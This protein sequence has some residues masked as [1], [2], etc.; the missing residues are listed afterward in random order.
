[1]SQERFDLRLFDT[2][3][4]EN[5]IDSEVLIQVLNG[6]QKAVQLIAMDNEGIE[7][8]ERAK[9]SAEIKRTYVLKCGIPRI[10]S[11]A[12]PLQLGDPSGSLFA[13]QKIQDVAGKLEICAE[14]IASGLQESLKGIFRSTECKYRVVE[15]FKSLLP[16]PGAQW[17]IGLSRTVASRPSNEIVL[18]AATQKNVKEFL[19]HR[20][21]TTVPQTVTGYL[22]AMDFAK[23]LI[24]IQYPETQ[25]IL[26]CSYDESLEIAL[27]ENR[28][29]LVQVTGKVVL[30][31][32]GQIKEIIEVEDI[33]A[34]D[35]SDFTVTEVPF[36]KGKLRF[37]KPLVL[38]PDQSESL[39]LL[40]LQSTGL[41]IDVSASTRTGLLDEIEEQI[42]ALWIEY[43]R[44]SDSNLT[45]PAKE[46][47][48]RLLEAIEEIHE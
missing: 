24:S 36:K 48:K 40:C 23:R 3:R 28:R 27:I 25:K 6:L 35:L 13:P 29:D 17:K 10:G 15:A 2:D 11:Y 4:D 33:S 18:T 16:K 19:V 22:H 42:R 31:E 41:G 26:Q 43:A 5:T 34:V 38:K 7:V 14:S 1:M 44:E 12:L 9:A 47:K 8:R 21:D 39:Q 20:Q 45:E 32:D 30:F 46:L 37:K